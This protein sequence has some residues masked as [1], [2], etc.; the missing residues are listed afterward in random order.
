MP[1]T[2]NQPARFVEGA[3][4]PLS[5][6]REAAGLPFRMRNFGRGQWGQ[7]EWN[8]GTPE[9]NAN[10]VS[11][12]PAYYQ[13]GGQWVPM[14]TLENGMFLCVIPD[15]GLDS[16][17]GRIAV[18]PG[19]APAGSRPYMVFSE[20]KIYDE[21][22]TLADWVARAEDMTDGLI[23]P[24]LMQPQPDTDVWTTNTIDIVIGGDVGFHA[25]TSP[26]V[27]GVNRFYIQDDGYVGAT[28]GRN[29]VFEIVVIKDYTMPTLQRGL[30]LQIRD[31]GAES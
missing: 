28:L 4:S 29:R 16:P 27:V 10:M 13:E 17:L 9:A 12:A 31:F 7:V 19:L 30:K 23:Y 18:P 15:P 26:S 6:R 3:I 2:P 20:R 22:E 5:G 25:P 8:L 1:Y 21:R 14:P 24:R 11:Q